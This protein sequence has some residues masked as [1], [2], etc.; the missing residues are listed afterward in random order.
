MGSDRESQQNELHGCLI[1]FAP[2]SRMS[3]PRAYVTLALSKGFCLNW[4]W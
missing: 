2:G 3:G 1:D 4:I